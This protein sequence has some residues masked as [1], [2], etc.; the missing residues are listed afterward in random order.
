MNQIKLNQ[1][2]T[3][4]DCDGLDEALSSLCAVEGYDREIRLYIVWCARQVEH[5]MTD[6]R[7]IDALDVSERFANG[8]ATADELSIASVA[9]DAAASDV[10]DAAA[11][12]TQWA[13]QW[14]ASCATW[15]AALAASCAASCAAAG[16]AQNAAKYSAGA[17]NFAACAT[18]YDPA[19]S[20]NSGREADFAACV[21]QGMRLREVCA[22]PD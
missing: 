15:D 18:A 6:K 1:L 5:L 4:L 12:A 20:E 9:A 2:V 11:K 8:L 10:A 13:T 17:A 7:S 14:N 21:A 22:A 19:N 3:V 16:E